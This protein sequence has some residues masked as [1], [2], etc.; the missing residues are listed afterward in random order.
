MFAALYGTVALLPDD[1]RA[2]VAG[3]RH[4]QVPRRSGPARLRVPTSWRRRTGVA[5]PRRPALAGRAGPGRRGLAGAGRQLARRRDR[6]QRPA[7]PLDV[8]VIRFPRIS[9]FTDLDPLAIE[10]GVSVRLVETAVALGQ[11]D[12][13]VLPG[14]KSTV[15]DLGWLRDAG[16]AAA[17]RQPLDA[18]PAARTTILGI[19][20]GYQML[21]T[22]IHD[23]VEAR[24][25]RRWR[26][27]PAAVETVFETHKVTRWVSGCGRRSPRYAATRSTTAAPPGH[28]LVS[29]TASDSGK[30]CRRPTGECRHQPARPVRERPRSGRPSSAASPGEPAVVDCQRGLVRRGPGGP[31]RPVGF[32]P[33]GTPRPRR[34][35]WVGGPGP[36]SGGPAY[37]GPSDSPASG[38]GG[39]EP[40]DPVPDQR[41]ERDPGPALDR[42]R[43]SRTAFPPCGPARRPGPICPPS[44]AAEVVMVRLLGG[45]QRLG[46]AVRRAPPALRRRR[47]P[48]P[49]LRRRGRARRPAHR[50]VD[51]CRAPRWPRPSSTWC[52]GGLAN[53]EHLLR[54][55]S[56]TVCMTGFGF[57][58]PAEVPATGVYRRS[59][60]DGPSRPGTVPHVAVLFYRAHLVAGNTGFVDDLCDGAGGSGRRRSP[61]C[62]ATACARR[63]R[64]GSRP[65]I[66]WPPSGPMQWSRPCWCRDPQPMTAWAGMPRP[67]RA[68][69]PGRSG[70]HRHH[71]PPGVGGG[72]GGTLSPGRRHARGAAGVRRSHRRGAVLVQRGGRRRRHPRRRRSAPTAPCPTGWP[73]SPGGGPP[74]R[75]AR[76][77]GRRAS[78]GH[79]AVRLSDR[80]QPHR[81]RG[82]PRHAGLGGRPPTG[83]CRRRLPGRPH[84][85]G[86]RRPHGRAHRDLRLR[87]CRP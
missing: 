75:I 17:I 18:N 42:S 73:G 6:V 65:S 53:L 27:R 78:G 79:R 71:L 12:L 41:P 85:D 24:P 77:P 38:H 76:H 83:P 5:D 23:S 81:Q 44:T 20:G 72:H 43:G 36:A 63:R 34:H 62:G 3:L 45:D 70:H 15:A 9:N 32:G 61:R 68:G 4:Q 39:A 10:P 69:R 30:G 28:A 82:G 19:C 11:P 29:W 66:C 16:L 46:G 50:G 87:G 64:A 52:T 22:R 21:G 26:A 25:P 86:R 84:P 8:A 33:G 47:H 40:D 31:I 80:P 37:A 60:I 13:L 1:L 35:R 58:P 48:A 56:D 14:T 59:R 49:G 57:D 7:A 55:V 51:A 2:C 54:F 74:G 67:G